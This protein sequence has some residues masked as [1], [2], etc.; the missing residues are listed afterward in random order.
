MAV[1]ARSLVYDVA[2]PVHPRLVCRGTDTAIH[3]LGSNAIAYTTVVANHVVIVRRDLLTRAESQVAQLRVSPQ[4]Y[5]WFAATWSWDGS[6]EVYSTSAPRANGSW[7]VSVH[8]W[9]RGADHVLYSIESGVGGIESRWAQRALL[10]FSPDHSYVAISDTTYSLFSNNVRVFLLADLRQK[11]VTGGSTSG[12]TW[13][14]N[15]RLVWANGSHLLMQWTPSVGATSLRT[16]KWYGVASSSDGLW[17]AGTLLA[18]V[19]APRVF[20]A[21]VGSGRT[22]RTGLASSPGFV[23]PTVVWYALEA[24][25]QATYDPTAPTGV[26]HALDVV[27]Q[28]DKVVAFRAGEAPNTV[29]CSAED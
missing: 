25:S 6:L 21:P 4:P 13:I 10:E 29:C 17:L 12:G 2:D 23:T 7:L 11:F 8:L 22:F 5:Y 9:S 15:D 1:I 16:E 18:D 20:I 24:A 28:T 27:T 19:S 26:I 14:A 3:L